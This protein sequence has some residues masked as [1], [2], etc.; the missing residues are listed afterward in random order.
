MHEVISL[1]EKHTSSC[2]SEEEY[3]LYS[4]SPAGLDL[5]E[6]GLAART[7]LMR[8]QKPKWSTGTS[9]P[10]VKA[11]DDAAAATASAPSPLFDQGPTD[12]KTADAVMNE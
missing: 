3:T 4:E 1:Y 2:N 9:D 7:R 11:A 5:R 8:K 6:R 12:T 10:S